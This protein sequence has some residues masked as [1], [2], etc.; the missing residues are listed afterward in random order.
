MI[1]CAAHILRLFEPSRNNL[2]EV[3]ES[4]QS[5]CVALLIP[6]LDDVA[7]A[8]QDEAVLATI[9]I[10]R[11]SEQYDE[12]HVDRQCHLVPG[13]FSHF[14]ASG[15][16]STTSGGLRQATFYSYVRADIRMAILGRCGT[17]IS[18]RSWPLSEDSPFT[19]ADWANRMTWLLVHAINLHYNRESTGRMPYAQLNTLVD[20]WMAGAPSTFEPY[21]YEENERD[22]FPVVR[23]LCPWHGQ[24]VLD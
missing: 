22:P 21:F 11:M 17:K 1:A 3:E 13:A 12:Y 10:L 7:S 15:P 20:E 19:D 18:L 16:A 23:L 9:G 24:C 5:Q 2:A 6:V 4:N 14:G 8:I